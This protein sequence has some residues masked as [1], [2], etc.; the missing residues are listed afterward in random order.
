VLSACRNWS[1]SP[2]RIKALKRF[3]SACKQGVWR[4][5]LYA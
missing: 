3:H 1:V 5:Y 2:V 4:R